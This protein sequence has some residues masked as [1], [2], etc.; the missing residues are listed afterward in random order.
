MNTAYEDIYARYR[1]RVRNYDMLDLEM[2]QGELYQ[3]DLLELAIEDFEEICKQDLENRDD[4]LRSFGIELTARE[5]NILS[6]G[7]VVHFVEPYVYN[8]DAL[9]NAL[10]TKDFSLYSPANLLEKMTDLLKASKQELRREINL[11]SFRNG[12]VANM[13]AR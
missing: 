7:M 10:S 3:K 13:T 8:T 9:Q 6:L 1:S 4:E 12:D 5:K 11:Y 2:A